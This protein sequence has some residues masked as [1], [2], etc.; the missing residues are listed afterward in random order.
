MTLDRGKYKKDNGQKTK[1]RAKNKREETKANADDKDKRPLQN[2]D[3]HKGEDKIQI[4]TQM[5]R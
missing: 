1:T 4:Q 3:T 5:L 2:E